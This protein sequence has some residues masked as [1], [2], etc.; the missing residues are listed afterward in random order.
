MNL[1][2]AI[3][4]IDTKSDIPAG[5]I[6][7]WKDKSEELQQLSFAQNK[8]MQAFGATLTMLNS[9]GTSWPWIDAWGKTW[10]EGHNWEGRSI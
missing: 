5:E 6:S 3:A 9:D 8:M 10:E 4:F 1:K 7:S 2:V